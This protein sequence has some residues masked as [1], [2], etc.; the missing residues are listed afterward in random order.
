M[1]GIQ[2]GCRTYRALISTTA[3]RFWQPV[4]TPKTKLL[5]VNRWATRQTVEWRNFHVSKTSYARGLLRELRRE[6]R[7]AQMRGRVLNRSSPRDAIFNLR[8]K[9]KCKCERLRASC[10]QAQHLPCQLFKSV[11]RAY[12]Y[13]LHTSMPGKMNSATATLSTSSLTYHC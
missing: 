9:T 2:R 11:R 10:E 7:T 6:R 13:G 8:T 3:D 4:C 12:T 1:Q 5:I